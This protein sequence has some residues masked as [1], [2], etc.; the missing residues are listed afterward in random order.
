MFNFFKK[1][2]KDESLEDQKKDLEKFPAELSDEALKGLDCDV[3]SN[4]TGEF[5]KTE[6]N[7]IPVNGPIGEIKYLN[8]LMTDDGGL[9]IHRLGSYGQLDVYEVVSI[10]GKIWDILY[11]DMYHPRRSRST[12]KG[13]TFNKFHEIFTKFAIGYSTN[14]FDPDFPFGLSK[15]IE[16]HVG[17]TLG[18]RIAKKYEEVIEDRSKFIRPSKHIEKLNQI[19]LTGRL[20]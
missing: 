4:V 6:T 14:S 5:G 12:P 15:F 9:I 3:L 20:S 18:V 19:K 1:Q 8:R 2:F 11:L 13:Y 17:S 10:G 16:K 7:P